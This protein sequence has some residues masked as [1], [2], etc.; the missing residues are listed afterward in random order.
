MRR[1]GG[2]FHFRFVIP[3]PNIFIYLTFNILS[4]QLRGRLLSRDAL[5]ERVTVQ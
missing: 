4:I 3:L 2:G 5:N 1:R